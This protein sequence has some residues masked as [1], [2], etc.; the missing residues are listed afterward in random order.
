MSKKKILGGL[1]ALILFLNYGCSLNDTEKYLQDLKSENAM[2]INNAI[3]YL[4]EE[5]EKR[6]VPML[7]ELLNNDQLKETRLNA[8]EALG[9]IEEDSS[10]EALVALLNEEDK[11]IKTASCDALGMIKN[12]KAVRHLIR[13]LQDK[14][15]RLTAIWALGNIEDKS[16]VPALTTLLDDKDKYV[17]SNAANA[18]KKIGS[19]SY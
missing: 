2:V 8:I 13:I 11:E 15:V 10:V 18:L 9:K 17:S 1:L 12:A 6:A 5:E 19:V 14:D 4:G 16:A 7:I 3:Y